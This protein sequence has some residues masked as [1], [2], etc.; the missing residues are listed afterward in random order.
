MMRRRYELITKHSIH[1]ANLC[2]FRKY[3]CHLL[4]CM[5]GSERWRRSRM[6]GVWMSQTDFI[7]C[8]TADGESPPPGP[9]KYSSNSRGGGLE[10]RE[11]VW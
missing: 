9:P 5:Q 2:G 6:E 1:Q 4:S 10:L 7:R 3:D 8:L 11:G